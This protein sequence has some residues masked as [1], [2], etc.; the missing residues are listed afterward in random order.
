MDL[1]LPNQ[2]IN[3]MMTSDGI[4]YGVPSSKGKKRN[5]PLLRQINSEMTGC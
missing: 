3:R 1:T 5:K 2:D 4:M